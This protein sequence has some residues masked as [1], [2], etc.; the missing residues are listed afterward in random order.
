MK[1]VKYTPNNIPIEEIPI[2]EIPNPKFNFL[3]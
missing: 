1:F 3:D 2:K